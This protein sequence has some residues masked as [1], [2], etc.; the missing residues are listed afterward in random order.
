MVTTAAQ[1]VERIIVL[2][3]QKVML[4]SGPAKPAGS[5][6][7]VLPGVDVVFLRVSAGVGPRA[8]RT[9]AECTG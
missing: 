3:G 7:V 5:G 8:H 6:Y 9:P 4:D 1:I 2:R